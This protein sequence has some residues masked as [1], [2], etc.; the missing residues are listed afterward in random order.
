MEAKSEAGTFSSVTDLNGVY[1][2]PALNPGRYEI[3]ANLSGFSPATSAPVDRRSGTA[4]QGRSVAEDRGRRGKR[5]GHRG[6]ADD[7]RQADDGRDEPARRR[8]RSHAEGA[9]FHVAGDARAWREPRKPQRRPVRSTARRRPRTSSTWT[10]STR[11]T[12]GPASRPRRSSPISSGKCRSSRP[13]TPRNSAA[14]RAASSASSPRAARTS[15]AARSARTSTATALNGDLALNNTAGTAGG[16]AL[17]S[18]LAQLA[19]GTTGVRRALRLVLSGANEA[20]T[21]L[22]PKDDY[23][24]WDPH[25]QVGGPIVRDKLW[26]WAGYTPQLE[27]TDRIGHVPQ[28]RRDGRVLEHRD[29]AEPGRQRDLAGRPM[30]GGCAY[31]A[32]TVRSSRTAGCRTSTAPATPRRSSRRSASSRTT[33]R[34]PAA[35]TGW[36]RTGSS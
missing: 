32:R 7:R 14:R 33:S 21:V 16:S 17:G 15:S 22:Y 19:P 10:A 20:E 25:F 13:A 26:F 4:P 27:N 30:P 6:I 2:F 18:G 24:R 9:R 29:D 5:A 34:R 28:H 12:S 31:P 8:D 11:R 1:R 3:T 36:R 23:S 35:W